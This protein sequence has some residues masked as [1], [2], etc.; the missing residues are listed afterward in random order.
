MGKIVKSMTLSTFELSQVESHISMDE[1]RKRA[2][3]AQK[4]CLEG[5]GLLG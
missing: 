2:G 4:V 3:V 1:A 5:S